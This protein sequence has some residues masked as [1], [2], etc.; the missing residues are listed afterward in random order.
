LYLQGIQ[1]LRLKRGVETI[2]FG[3]LKRLAHMLPTLAQSMFSGNNN[4]SH[5][6]TRGWRVQ[7]KGGRGRVEGGSGWRERE[8]SRQRGGFGLPGTHSS[9]RQQCVSG[10][11]LIQSAA[12][13]ARE[14][15]G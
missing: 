9:S 12:A 11:P 7:L 10:G 14:A 5:C 4:T 6:L 2:S 8:T 13:S 15:P 1:S 3:E